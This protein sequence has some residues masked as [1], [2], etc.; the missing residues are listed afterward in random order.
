MAC[1]AAR[2]YLTERHRR[3]A[4]RWAFLRA[5]PQPARKT[6]SHDHAAPKNRRLRRTLVIV[7]VVLAVGSVAVGVTVWWLLDSRLDR[8]SI[9]ALEQPA[10]GPVGEAPPQ[11]PDSRDGAGATASPS[12]SPSASPSPT[13]Q[14]V[15]EFLVVGSD[16]RGDLTEEERRELS[17]GKDFGDPRTDVILLIQLRPDDQ[18]ATIVSV[19]RDL[20]V[21]VDGTDVKINELMAEG[22]PDLLVQEVE[23]LSGLQLDHYLEVS[24]PTFLTVV[25]AVGGAEVCLD[26][27]LVDDKAG[28]DLPAGCQTLDAPDALAFVR[29][30]QGDRGDFARIAR[31]Q[32]FLASLADEVRSARTLLDLPRLLR[33]VNRVAGSITTD[34]AMTLGQLRSLAD[35]L[36]DLAGGDLAAVTLPAYA[37][38][39]GLRSYDPG[40]TALFEAMRDDAPL[41][42][43]G[44]QGARTDADVA[45][46]PSGV[47]PD[48][49]RVESTLYFAGYAPRVASG[50]PSAPPRTV[51]H[52]GPDRAEVATWVANLL[53]APLEPLPDSLSLG[54]EMD[55][56]VVV[57][58]G[59]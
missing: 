2:P 14:G 41:P 43:R 53:G 52:A 45:L 44:P 12:P 21:E 25:D 40:A 1:R 49:I 10:D 28:A 58:P 4:L 55:A 59:P 17:T 38:E 57:G 29:S 35:E 47:Y 22:G 50:G 32:Q 42:P 24:I 54:T 11:F 39:G 33:V 13:L 19:P 51:V 48:A 3:A 15:T 46:F 8:R 7:A 18:R 36:G 31:Q 23:E 6:L 26:Q 9:Q 16:D 34:D 37:V 20:L 27:P 5:V 30:R 56:V